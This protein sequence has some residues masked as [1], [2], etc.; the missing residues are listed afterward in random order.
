MKKK[1]L[2]NEAPDRQSKKL[3]I[4][5]LILLS[6]TLISFIPHYYLFREQISTEQVKGA[7]VTV[8]CATSLNL[9]REHA[10]YGSGDLVNHLYLVDINY[11]S[12][13]FSALKGE[14]VSSIMN[15]KQAGSIR[16]VSVYLR[17]FHDASWM[18]IGGDSSYYPGSLMKVPILIYYLRE[19]ENHPGL[20]NKK[21]KFERPSIKFPVQKFKGDSIL[22]GKS[23]AVSE[24]LRYMIVESDNNAAYVLSENIE[25]KAFTHIFT[26]LNIPPNNFQTSY[27]IRPR[28]YAKF[29]RILYSSTYLSR[30]SSEYALELLARSKFRKGIVQKLPSDVV[31]ARKF[32]E[33]GESKIT[34]FSE[35]AIIYKGKTPYLLT[36]MTRGS[37]ID[38]QAELVSEISEKVF[39]AMGDY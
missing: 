24:L 29:F 31:V 2:E 20:L 12:D 21:L 22:P 38:Q 10:D 32:G 37:D 6:G 26:D 27:Q 25:P 7:A 34:D 5:N 18:S 8:D 13:R 4:L 23:Y 14:L 30:K 33:H 15:K 28:E 16:D 3:L 36:V 39:K 11:E 1:Y 17:D 9:I 35:S 19:E